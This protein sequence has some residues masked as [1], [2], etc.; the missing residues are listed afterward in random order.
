MLSS[1]SLLQVALVMLLSSS[2]R[3]LTTGIQGARRLLRPLSM[4]ISDVA[5]T[6]KAFIEDVAKFKAPQRLD[7]LLQLLALSGEEIVAPTE[8]KSVDL[9]PFLIP[10]SRDKEHRMTCYLRW[11]T[12]KDS[13]D[14]QL[15]QTTE[16][17]V[18][19]RAQSTDQ[20][21]RRIVAE[22]DFLSLP[23]AQEA[24]DILQKGGLQYT[25]GEFI[26]F[27]KSGEAMV[28][29]YEWADRCHRK[30]RHLHSTGSATRAGSVPAGKSRSL[31]RLL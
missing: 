15:V 21:A 30:V 16:V 8:R 19:L 6:H 5:G 26:P 25:L 29:R 27:L 17:G 9:N 24:V 23:K 14:L 10:I 13:M 2:S 3:G 11:P 28:W 20:L 31:P 22:Q 18:R 4:T 12:Q 7:T 1:A